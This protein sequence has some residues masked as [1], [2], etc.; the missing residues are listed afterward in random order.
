MSKVNCVYYCN[1]MNEILLLKEPKLK[2]IK[3]SLEVAGIGN[4]EFENIGVTYL[5]RL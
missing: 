1:A 2:K 3:L 4:L 5:G